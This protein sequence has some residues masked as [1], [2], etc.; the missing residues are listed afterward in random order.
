MD[1]HDFFMGDEFFAHEFFGA[2]ICG[3]NVTFR[4]W[5]PNV[6][7][8]AV[9]GDFNN[10]TPEPMISDGGTGFYEKT[11]P[12]SAGQY[13]KY[14]LYLRDGREVDHCDPYGF[15]SA[16]RPD[17]ASRVTDMSFDWT[18]GDFM[19]GRDKGYDRPVNIYEVHLGSWLRNPDDEENGW[20]AYDEIAPKLIDYVKSMGYTHI[21]IMP[22]GE[23]PFD[24]SW[25]YQQTGYF[26]PTSRYGTAAQLKK[27]INSCHEAGIYVITDFVPVHF[28][29]N[30]YGLAE[31]DGVGVYEY[32]NE[33][34]GRSEWGTKNF[35][36]FRGE[37]RSFLQSAA[38]FWLGEFHFDGIRMD[39]ISN[40][41]YWQGDSA[42]GVNEGAVNFVRSMNGRLHQLHPG[43][44]LIAEDSSNFLKVTAPAE[45]GG[46]GF[47]YKWDMGWMNDTLEFFRTDPLFRGGSYHKLSFSMMYF[48]N[49]LYLLPFSHD[50]VVHGKATII[51]KM[52]GDYEVKFPQCRALYAYMYTHPGKKLNFM[53]SE[54]AQF[55]EWDE[56]K[57]PDSFLL[58]YP[59]HDSFKKYVSDLNRLYL[60]E[61][62]LHEKEYDP[63]MF[64]WLQVDDP[65]HVVYA[66]QRGAAGNR[67][68]TVLNLSGNEYAG[69]ALNVDAASALEP[70]INSDWHPYSGNTPVNTAAVPVRDGAAELTLPP[71]SA[72]I[73]KVVEAE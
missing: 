22:L 35:N 40:C 6:R 48:Y 47:D 67:T 34:A 65:E 52:W 18:D 37:V 32:P 62:S 30:D 72:I 1:Q 23:H 24:G 10:W 49:E 54:I 19:R 17:W 53:G 5:A 63:A 31:L 15:G 4:L 56:K 11:L 73:F 29:V 60:T 21:E 9:M 61:S 39:A 70:L 43:A 14:R 8:A 71:M 66:Y 45:Y 27:L 68:V 12:A 46:L 51:Q 13:Y 36:F 42:R 69:Y 3:E 44:V 57:E 2:H 64:R 16:L 25:G 7:G 26:C 38:N 20:Y 59:L 41:I 28:A 55:R 33:G 50:E 58:E